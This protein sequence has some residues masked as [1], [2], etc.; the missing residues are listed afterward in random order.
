LRN[1]Y[2]YSPN[3]ADSIDGE[4]KA[5][6]VAMPAGRES[7]HVTMEEDK[8]YKALIKQRPKTDK[9]WIVEEYESSYESQEC[10]MRC[11]AEVKDIESENE[12]GSGDR[13]GE[14][15]EEEDSSLTAASTLR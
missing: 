7:T 9:P 4:S 13:E 6:A 11:V 2:E 10:L 15:A 8:G 12:K 14:T 5:N 1:D 3:V